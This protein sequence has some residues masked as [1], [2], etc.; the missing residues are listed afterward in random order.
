MACAGCARRRQAIAE[1]FKGKP[2]PESAVPSSSDIAEQRAA[3]VQEA[4]SWTGTPFHDETGIKG[5][6]ADCAWFPFR[7]Y[8]ALGLIPPFEMP[9]YSPQFMM[10]SSEDFY[11]QFVWPHA[12]ETQDPQPGDFGMWFYGKCYSHGAIVIKWP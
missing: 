12:V 5:V 10:N 4:L 6:G 7:V 11:L 8:T 9:R 1:F 3:V 2:M